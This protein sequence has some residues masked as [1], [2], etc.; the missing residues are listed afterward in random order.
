MMR[1]YDLS[2]IEEEIIAQLDKGGKVFIESGAANDRIISYTINDT[3]PE[4]E[5]AFTST[6]CIFPERIVLGDIFDYVERRMERS[7]FCKS[8]MMTKY[9]ICSQIIRQE[10]KYV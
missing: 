1:Q 5:V 2:C 7:Y 4:R 6:A 9:G 10:K 3:P 8:E